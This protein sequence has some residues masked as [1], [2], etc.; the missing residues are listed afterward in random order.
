MTQLNV[1]RAAAQIRVWDIGWGCNSKKK[2]DK[3]EEDKMSLCKHNDKN[4][5]FSFFWGGNGAKDTTI[6][7][8]NICRT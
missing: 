1:I 8:T 6:T 4:V 5:R 7:V 2:E 3:K